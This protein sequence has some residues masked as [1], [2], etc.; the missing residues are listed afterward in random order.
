MFLLSSATSRSARAYIRKSCQGIQCGDLRFQ[1]FEAPVK[2]S[3][4]FQQPGTL[5]VYIVEM[6]Q[7][8]ESSLVWLTPSSE[9]KR[10]CSL[11]CCG[12]TGVRKQTYKLS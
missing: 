2:Q 4:K 3:Q 9:N 10:Y 6:A 12:Q 7:S 11:S 8:S 1:I 5:K